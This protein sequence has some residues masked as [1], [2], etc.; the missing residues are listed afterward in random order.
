MVEKELIG[1][2]NSKQLRQPPSV[3]FLWEVRPGIPKRDWKPGA[4]TS[5]RPVPKPPVKLIAS[6]PFIWEEKP[7]K[8]LPSFSL[9]PQDSVPPTPPPK[10]ISHPSPSTYSHSYSDDSFEADVKTFRFETEDSFHSPPSLLANCL[11][12]LTRISTA[13]PV[14][15]ISAV[16]DKSGQ[17][18]TLSSPTSETDS[19]TSSY[20]TGT[21]SLVGAPF[22]ECLF[23]LLPPNSG[24]LE[25]VGY[26]GNDCQAPPE[27]KSKCYDCESNSSVLVR[28][29]PTLGELIMMS[30]RRS[31][32]RK[33]VQMKKQNLSMVKLKLML[34]LP[35]CLSLTT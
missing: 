3:P 30:R 14:E 21:A 9:P 24:F 17:L 19:S 1:N 13:V 8:P 4:A 23:P 7:G 16:E 12:S 25:K 11:V 31:Y 10:L 6:V 26:L 15:N 2:S 27:P 29:A 33:A 5:V 20:A 35:I 28:R 18:E 22:L 32:Q 34:L